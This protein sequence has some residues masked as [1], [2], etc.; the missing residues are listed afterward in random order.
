MRHLLVDDGV[1]D[2]SAVETMR[3][4]HRIMLLIA[5][6]NSAQLFGGI[7]SLDSWLG[8]KSVEN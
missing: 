4:S 7:V 2:R 6:K 3:Q 8:V 5:G 1:L